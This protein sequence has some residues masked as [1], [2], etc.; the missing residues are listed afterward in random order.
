MS[1]RAQLLGRSGRPAV[2]AR[3]RPSAPRHR[4]LSDMKIPSQS[5][6]ANIL[7]AFAVGV[8]LAMCWIL[9]HTLLLIY[10]SIVFA[11]VFAPLVRWIERRHIGKWH[12]P[13]GVAVLV[14]V[15]VVFLAL[16]G[17]GVL[18]ISRVAGDLQNFTSDLPHQLNALRDRVS[19]LPFGRRIAPMMNPAALQA[20]LTDALKLAAGSLLAISGA[21]KDLFLLLILTAYFII[22]ARRSF[23][24]VMSLIGPEERSRLEE[25]LRRAAARMQRWLAGQSMLMLILA[26]LSFL[27]FWLL[28]IR[29]FFALALLAG[30]ANFVPIIGPVVS[31]VVAAVVAAIDSWTKLI[32]VVVFYVLYQQLENS[33]LTPRIMKSTVELP[34]ISVVLALAI[35]GTLAGIGGAIIAVPTAALIATV[36]NEYFRDK[37]APDMRRSQVG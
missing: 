6:R 33:I 7:F 10:L 17:G 11:V 37:A 30:A 14:L 12:P 22:D 1:Q 4:T 8:L 23:E 27:V 21:V 16:V 25:T 35:G 28:G 9:R 15:V 18:L 29:Y 31:F 32:G 36:I 5:A 13:T 19:D 20:R 34:A 26:S 24:W 3:Q 2:R